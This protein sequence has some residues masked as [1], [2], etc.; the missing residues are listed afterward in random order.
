MENT[1]LMYLNRNVLLHINMIE[2]IKHHQANIIQA[3]KDGVVIFDIPSETYMISCN[4]L[5][6]YKRLLH[7]IKD[8]KECEV[9]QS[10]AK[11]FVQDKYR[12][13]HMDT[14]YQAAFLEGHALTVLNPALKIRCLVDDDISLVKKYY[15]ASDLSYVLSR[16]K[17]K[18]L[19]GGF[20]NNVLVGFIGIHDE[21]SI[22]LLAVV[23]KYRRMGCGLKL[24]N[25][26]IRY[27]LVNN[28][29]PYS[30]ISYT[31]K[32]S[33]LLHQKAGMRISTETVEWLKKESL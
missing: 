10:W 14:Y 16:F 24:M 33:I 23:E 32:P 2:S 15:P 30:Q 22:G 19:F 26:M 21:G 31:N 27:F 8:I 11:C 28:N 3:D 20:L 17:E 18:Y 29:V 12:L 6:D 4:T 5:E 1:A 25:F 9:F 13:A 7:D